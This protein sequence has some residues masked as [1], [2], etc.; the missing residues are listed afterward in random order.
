MTRSL[1]IT[2][3]FTIVT[4]SGL[5]QYMS[6][7][8]RFQVAA[9]S[10][11]APFTLNITINVPHVYDGSNPCDSDD[12][13]YIFFL[14][15]DALYTYAQPGTYWLRIPC[16]STGIDSLQRDVLYHTPPPFDI[17]TCG[18]NQVVYSI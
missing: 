15:Y 14:S 17:Y 18:G 5:A 8:G 2:L 9:Q 13:G 10:G 4:A 6:V 7:G 12:N 16:Q 3:L 11:C 1:F